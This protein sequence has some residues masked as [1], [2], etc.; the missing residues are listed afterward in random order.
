MGI[1]FIIIVVIVVIVAISI[2]NRQKARARTEELLRKRKAEIESYL[3]Q[4]ESGEK[5]PED[6]GAA[7]HSLIAFDKVKQDFLENGGL[8]LG[9]GFLTFMGIIQR[10]LRAGYILQYIRHKIT[11]EYNSLSIIIYNGAHDGKLEYIYASTKSYRSFHIRMWITKKYVMGIVLSEKS[12]ILLGNEF[13]LSDGVKEPLRSNFRNCLIK[14][15]EES[16]TLEM[17]KNGLLLD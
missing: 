7:F 13:P 14:E 8:L 4:Y 16:N 12:Y 9:D 1:I 6:Y 15:L 11:A 5:S 3:E 17:Y 2:N 10:L